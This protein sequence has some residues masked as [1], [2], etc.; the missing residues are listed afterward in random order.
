[1]GFISHHQKRKKKNLYIGPV[2]KPGRA[3]HFANIVSQVDSCDNYRIPTITG[4]FL[5]INRYC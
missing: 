1:M 4:F 5:P 2:L 3:V